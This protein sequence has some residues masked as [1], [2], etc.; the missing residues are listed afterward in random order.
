MP[1]AYF[2]RIQTVSGA[3]P[4]SEIDGPVLARE[5]L[6]TDTRWGIGVDSDPYRWLD[7]ERYVVAE[8]KNLASD[9]GL[10]LVVE[11][12]CIGMARDPSSLGRMATGSRVAVVA[13]TGFAPEPFSGDAIRR[14][15]VDDLTADLL[16]EIGAGLDGAGSRP[17]LIV[18]TAWDDTPTAAEERALVA[19]ARACLRTDLP[20]ATEGL[21]LLELLL[22][23]GVP[24]RR[25]SARTADAPAQRKIAETGAYVSVDDA[26]DVLALLDAGHA[27]RVLLSSGVS[28][29]KDLHGYG[30]HGYGR[31][32]DTILPALSEAGVDDETRRLITHENPLRWLAG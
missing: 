18:A 16:H 27:E 25:L 32:F 5:H 28:R 4:V 2:P 17:G 7:E 15:S 29:Q 21:G 24:A 20:V 12:T 23:H 31:L 10:S 19:A 3:V 26:E 11:H 8:L 13:A 9:R 6:R 22:S 30:G 1:G 14:Y